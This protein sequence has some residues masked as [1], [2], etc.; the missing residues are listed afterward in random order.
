[1]AKFAH[2]PEFGGMLLHLVMVIDDSAIAND[3]VAM[4]RNNKGSK[5]G[6]K[7]CF[8]LHHNPGGALGT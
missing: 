1:M 7:L 4:W 2:G 3:T 5:S 8:P 6:A